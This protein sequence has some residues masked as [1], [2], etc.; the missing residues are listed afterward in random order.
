MVEIKENDQKVWGPSGSIDITALG[1]ISFCIRN[2]KNLSIRYMQADIR[3]DSHIL[4]VIF[5]EC[6]VQTANYLIVKKSN[7]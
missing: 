5:T 7:K 4:Y 1:V 6:T 2:K 3:I